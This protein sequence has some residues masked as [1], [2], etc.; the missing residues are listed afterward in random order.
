MVFGDNELIKFLQSSPSWL[1]DGTFKL[2]PKTFYQLYTVHIQCPGIAPACVYG[3]LPN[4]TEGTYKLF[5]DVLLSLLPN[6]AP[7]KV[8]I[9]FEL[10]A[11]KTFKKALPNATISGSF[12]HLS[13]NFI[14]KIGKLGLKNLY[15]SIPELSLALKLIPALAFEKLESVKSSF[16]LVV[17]NIQEVCEQLS[18][19]SSEVEKIDELCSY[20]QKTYKEKNLRE[21]LFL[22]SI[23]NKREAASE[24]VA[25]TT[26]AVEGWHFG[27][28]A[29]FSGWHPS[30][31]R[32]LENLKKDAA[33]QKYLYLQS[34]AGTELSRREKYRQLEAKMKNAIER[35]QDEN[36]FAFL[37]AMVSLSMSNWTSWIIY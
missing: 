26:N 21:P 24:G 11:I 35:L 15:R 14:G 29:F 31:W 33:T 32:T 18:L 34:T 36:T 27:I 28:Q 23:W 2:S 20:F 3:F 8:L 6:A 22:P 4:K 5:L 7:D 10:A 9:D 25:S 19:D 13:Q 1:A 30:L 12:F 16:K 17:E 37:R